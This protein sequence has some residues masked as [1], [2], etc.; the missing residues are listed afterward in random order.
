MAFS[1]GGSHGS[2][3]GVNPV[4]IVSSPGVDTERFVR[5]M[6]FHNKS[7]ATVTLTLTKY[8][9][10]IDYEIC[11][12]ELNDGDTL[13][14]GDGDHIVTQEGETIRAKLGSNPATNPSFV[15]SWGDDS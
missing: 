6:Y 4:E 10:S 2:L 3:N 7:G 14:F 8:V 11:V 9:S 13:Q 1:G 15:A 12:V 5:A